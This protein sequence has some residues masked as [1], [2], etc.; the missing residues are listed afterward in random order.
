MKKIILII[1]LLAVPLMAQYS[2]TSYDRPDPACTSFS[3]I[4]GATFKIYGAA[5]YPLLS[6]NPLSFQS[7]PFAMLLRIGS[8]ANRIGDS[9]AIIFAS[10]TTIL[11]TGANDHESQAIYGINCYYGSS[12]KSQIG[13]HG[14]AQ[15]RNATGDTLLQVAGMQAFGQ[16][17]TQGGHVKHLYAGFFNAAGEYTSFG[18]VDSMY[19]ISS[20][21]YLDGADTIVQATTIRAL[22][23]YRTATG[24]LNGARISH[25]RSLYVGQPSD[26]IGYN[27]A[28]EI[29]NPL[30][31]SG[32]QNLN[33][34]F[35]DS[36]RSRY[37]FEWDQRNMRF[38]LSKK[39]AIF[40]FDSS[41]S[42][43]LLLYHHGTQSAVA[44]QSNSFIYFSSIDSAT[45]QWAIG[46]RFGMGHNQLEF[47]H[48]NDAQF[49]IYPESLYTRKTIYK[50]ANNADSALVTK[51]YVDDNIGGSDS[52]KFIATNGDTASSNH[53]RI[54]LAPST[55][56]TIT[57]AND[58][59]Y[60]SGAGGASGT[61]DTVE[62]YQTNWGAKITSLSNTISLKPSTGIA[63]TL[64]NDT[65][66]IT[67]TLGVE[68]DSSEIKDGTI[69]GVD[70]KDTTITTGKIA[71][72]AIDSIRVAASVIDSSHIQNGAVG[73]EDLKNGIVNSAKIQD[74]S[75]VAADVKDSTIT[76]VKVGSA[77]IGLAN[78]ASSSVNSARIVDTS[79]V[80]ADIKDSTITKAKL[81]MASI[82]STKIASLGIGHDDIGDN[83][84]DS[85]KIPNPGVGRDD[86]SS[87]AVDSA[88]IASSS[89]DSVHIQNGGVA[90]GNLHINSVDSTKIVVSGVGSSE[91]AD[92]SVDSTDIKNASVAWADLSAQAQDSARAG[93]GGG[94]GTL[95]DSVSWAE[96]NQATKDSVNI[97]ADT[98]D[99]YTMAEFL[100]TV[101]YHIDTT[102]LDTIQNAH[103]SVLADSAITVGSETI[104]DKAGTQYGGTET[105]ITVTYD[106]ANNDID[107]VVALGTSID[108]SE[109]AAD[110]L[111]P[112]DI[113]WAYEWIHLTQVY[114]FNYELGTAIY[115]NDNVMLG[116]SAYLVI[117]SAG[118]AVSGDQDTFSIAGTIPYDC[119]ID[120][121]AMMVYGS[122][123][124][125]IDSIEFRGPHPNGLNM[126]DSTYWSSGT[127]LGGA[128]SVRTYSFTNDISATA[129]DRYRLKVRTNFSGANQTVRIGWI[130]IRIKR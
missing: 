11:T 73:R 50:Y 111:A 99:L 82:D 36:A 6:F 90:L 61:G 57:I 3:D 41:K 56:I 7:N 110:A 105:G 118:N 53:N 62:V 85:T 120:S 79:I 37:A 76:G 38:Q 24:I 129:G 128:L 121:L 45:K 51:K 94:G 95:G 113:N 13:I 23:P 10:D 33:I 83:I 44:I 101:A 19:G 54:F 32:A 59:A 4:S 21:I 130:K 115:L 103:K 96:L 64:A 125:I 91:I 87:Q 107:F 92:A 2:S 47:M 34:V 46:H 97:K 114:G 108:S 123:T 12:I 15:A 40:E 55:N 49:N 1:L 71:V 67:S 65:A 25:S 16:Q 119:V 43:E 74:T 89:I 117:D 112:S 26:A 58:T 9:R 86:I 27:S 98:A 116:E 78:M 68:I 17:I 22:E 93:T 106:D 31:T 5:D 104:Q 75:I 84:I 70:I 81:V 18:T 72:G 102:T 28:I 52:V 80:A 100:D 8:R 69:I 126:M 35:I 77:T 127:N 48:G 29:V 42:S 66:Y 39:L 60:I 30:T 14:I 122:S 20:R 88:K 63:I 109:V 124:S